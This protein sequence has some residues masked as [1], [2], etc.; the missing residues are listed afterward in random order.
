ME[1]IKREE[2]R[3]KVEGGEAIRAREGK[4]KWM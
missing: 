1:G 2:M 4:R 3:G